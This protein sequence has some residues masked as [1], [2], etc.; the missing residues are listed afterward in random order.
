M[1]VTLRWHNSSKS[2]D[3]RLFVVDLPKSLTICR[4]V[5][6][7]IK[8]YTT[9]PGWYKVYTHVIISIIILHFFR[10]FSKQTVLTLM[11]CRAFQTLS[12]V[13][14]EIFAIILFSQIALKHIFAKLKIRDKGVILIL[15]SVNDSD[16][17]NS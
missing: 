15:I 3:F 7:S 4:T 2:V 10:F 17:A 5:D 13:N 9:K 1:T 11:K 12:T 6:I 16:F 14:S 8:V